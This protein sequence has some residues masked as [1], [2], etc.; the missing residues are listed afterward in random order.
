MSK[1]QPGTRIR[2]EGNLTETPWK[3]NQKKGTLK[4]QTWVIIVKT[5]NDGEKKGRLKTVQHHKK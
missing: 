4:R 1:S 2:K 5:A 3:K